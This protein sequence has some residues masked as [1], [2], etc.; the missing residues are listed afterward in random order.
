MEAS[1]SPGTLS[2]LPRRRRRGGVWLNVALGVVLVAAALMAWWLMS[3]SSRA[4]AVTRTATV[5]KGSVL[6][7]VTATGNVAPARETALS[8]GASGEVTAVNVTVGQTVAAGDELARIDD[9]TARASLRSAEANLTAARAKLAQLQSDQTTTTTTAARGAATGASSAGSTPTAADISAARAAVVTAEASA[10]TARKT[11]AAVTITAPYGGVVSAVN[12][13]LGQT[14]GSNAA[15][16]AAGTSGG[17]GS[18]G[19]ATTATSG[20]GSG[21]NSGSGSSSSSSSGSGAITIIDTS[22]LTVTAAFSEADSSKVH[23]NQAASVSFDAI[24]GLQA[25]GRVAEVSPTSTVSNNVVTVPATVV[26]A[27]PPPQVKVGMTATV[28]VVADQRDAVLSLPTAAVSR[29]G[30]GATGTVQVV[31]DDGTT[32]PVQVQT[33][34]V[35]D[36]SI[37]ITSG[38]AEGQRVAV[39]SAS[40]PASSGGSGSARTGT[41]GTTQNRGGTGGFTGGGPPGGGG[42]GGPR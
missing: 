39:Q 19:S 29:Q 42:F 9:S 2:D 16:G 35:G 36:D 26:I 24:T 10:D 20:S 37:E 13:E 18:G 23:V 4:A 1:D 17:A 25:N 22:S 15:S 28:T 7:T 8:F 34:L 30:T 41:G 32:E 5:T 21:G 38:L 33:G 11:L 27:S 6:S 3:G 12:V 31:K 14:T 40:A